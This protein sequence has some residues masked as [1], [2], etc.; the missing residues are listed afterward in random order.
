[1][2]AI[3]DVEGERAG[4]GQGQVGQDYYYLAGGVDQYDQ[5]T[6]NGYERN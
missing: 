3:V 4:R 2:L 1:M 5:F 6:T